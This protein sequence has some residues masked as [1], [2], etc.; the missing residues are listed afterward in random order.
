MTVN[1][2]VRLK[3][4][5]NKSTSQTQGKGTF[6]IG[7][8]N[9][10]SERSHIKLTNH[11]FVVLKKIYHFFLIYF[12]VKPNPCCGRNNAENSVIWKYLNV[13]YKS[14]LYI[15]MWAGSLSG[16]IAIFNIWG[17]FVQVVYFLNQWFWRIL[18]HSTPF[19]DHFLL[20]R[21]DDFSFK[22]NLMLWY[23]FDG[24]WA[25][26]L[27][28]KWRCLHLKRINKLQSESSPEL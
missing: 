13:H 20:I 9:T 17:S 24:G 15:P 21:E 5:S 18:T 6:L 3:I 10:T 11:I 25:Y 22:N 8:V 2:H 16:Q 28:S 12:Y 1:G 27:R 26:I 14:S 23:N 4:L 7:K 19:I